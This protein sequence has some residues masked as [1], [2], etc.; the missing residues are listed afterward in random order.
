MVI[1]RDDDNT[2][3]KVAT[4]KRRRAERGDL[5]KNMIERE[6]G[7]EPRAELEMTAASSHNF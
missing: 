3:V 7:A 6:G 1:V 4:T 2:V 5:R